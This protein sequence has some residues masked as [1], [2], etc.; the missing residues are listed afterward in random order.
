MNS[1]STMITRIKQI[2]SNMS[3]ILSINQRNLH[4]IYPNNKRPD[5]PLADNKLRTKE[6]L[7]K[8][9]IPS[10]QTYYT[11]QYFYDLNRLTA[12]LESHS[13]F[14]IKPAC[15]KGGGGII[16]V[17]GRNGKKWQCISGRSYSIQ[18]IQKHI[19]DIIFGIHSLGLNDAAVIEERI[20]Q[21]AE[22]NVLSPFGLADVRII[23]CQH[24]PIMAMIRLA[25]KASHGTANLHQGAIGVGIDLETGTTRHAA[26]HGMS[27]DRHPDSNVYLLGHTI[28]YWQELI[29]ISRKVAESIPLKYLGI[30]ISISETGPKVL[31]IN[32]RPGIEIQ[33]VNKQG[34]R[35]ILN[36]KRDEPPFISSTGVN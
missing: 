31:E 5:Y 33:N 27:I 6:I 17:S 11:Y 22:I 7:Q 19:T 30:D 8:I 32:V 3:E 18:E 2:L 14:V 20:I 15:G 36:E 28:P 24:E 26:M 10:P 34:M 4:Y 25:T 21:H 13:D 16:V 29:S 12:D 9:G 1:L 35:A 23:I